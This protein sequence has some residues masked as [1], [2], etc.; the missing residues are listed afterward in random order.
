MY[1]LQHQ[2]SRLAI[3]PFTLLHEALRN[4]NFNSFQQVYLQLP[5]V[6]TYSFKGLERSPALEHRH[7]V[8]ELPLALI[9][10]VVTPLYGPPERLLPGGQVFPTRR[11]QLQPT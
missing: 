9:Q 5:I 10:Q 3:N 2:E 7:P 6:V 8:K 11:K 4:K 1:R